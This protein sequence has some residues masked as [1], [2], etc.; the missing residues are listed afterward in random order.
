MQNGG[1]L[2]FVWTKIADVVPEMRKMFNSPKHLLQHGNRC[3][4]HD[5]QHESQ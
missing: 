3:E 1:E 5:R 2:L 4:G